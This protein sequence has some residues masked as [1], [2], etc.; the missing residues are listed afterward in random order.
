[1]RAL[2]RGFQPAVAHGGLG[3]YWQHRSVTRITNAPPRVVSASSRIIA[4]E[5]TE[6]LAGSKQPE[7]AKALSHFC[8]FNARGAY[9][10]RLDN[11]G[12][13]WLARA[14]AN[15][16]LGHAGTLGHRVFATLVTLKWKER[17]SDWVARKLNTGP[18]VF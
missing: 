6:W 12:D 17:F 13:D 14:R 11:E 16:L 18:Q 3:V 8:Y 9:K 7:V 2:M 1:M 5:V 15:G 10:A 4:D